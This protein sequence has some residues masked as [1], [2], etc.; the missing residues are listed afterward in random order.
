METGE[1]KRVLDNAVV[2][3]IVFHRPGNERRANLG[4]VDTGTTDKTL[5]RLSKEIIDSVEYNRCI[6]VIDKARAWLH[7][8][9]LPSPLRRGTY[10]VALPLITTVAKRI[11]Q[12][13][14]D[15]A[16]A[17]DAFVAVYP[18]K[19]VEMRKRLDGQFVA[20]DY[21]SADEIR[22]AFS[23]E[24]RFVDFGVPSAEKVGI[25]LWQEE[26]RR[27]ENTW[28]KA[29]DTIEESLRKS[30]AELVGYLAE[31]LA[32]RPDG[33]RSRLSKTTL[34]PMLEFID[35]FRSRNITN[36]KELQ[37]LVTSAEQLLTGW[38]VSQL[39]N[40]VVNREALASEMRNVTTQLD[41][42][43]TEAPRRRIAFDD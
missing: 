22:A 7:S 41:K 2:L 37:E 14:L 43:L 39:R 27:A 40:D 32:V 19:I 25:E 21:R 10:L 36:D 38:N 28:S 4:I 6:S 26:Q 20:S 30:F 11:K 8:R 13:E 35:L 24:W 9:A 1:V 12:I 23:V 3:D 34:D 16:S 18:D 42:L 5:L 33:S 31:K 29:I 17:A 15:Y